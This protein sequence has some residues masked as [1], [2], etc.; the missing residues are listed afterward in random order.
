MLLVGVKYFLIRPRFVNNRI[1][2]CAGNFSALN[3]FSVLFVRANYSD[4]AVNSF[5]VIEE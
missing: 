2:D 1:Y 5:S 3:I 4:D